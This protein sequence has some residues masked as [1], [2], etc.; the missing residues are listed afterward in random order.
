[1]KTTFKVI[2]VIFLVLL[3]INLATSALEPKHENAPTSP[4]SIMADA[5]GTIK[6][7]LKNPASYQCVRGAMTPVGPKGSKGAEVTVTYRATNSFGGIVTE[8]ATYTYPNFE[9]ARK[10]TFRCDGTGGYFHQT[11]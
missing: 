6:S 5:G 9:V 4:A 10:L 8:S 2:G 7:Q 11:N 1:M 3:G